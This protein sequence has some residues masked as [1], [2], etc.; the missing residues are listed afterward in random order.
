AHEPTEKDEAQDVSGELALAGYCP[1][2][3]VEDRKLVKG[4]ADHALEHEGRTYR[5]ATSAA[6]ERFE[7]QPLRYR[8]WRNGECP[9][10]QTEEKRSMPGE[11][12]W[13][14]LYAGRLFVFASD[15]NRK[16]FVANPE[17]YAKSE[18]VD[19]DG[20]SPAEPNAEGEDR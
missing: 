18:R 15:S 12:R 10:V 4:H 9:V 5:F 20:V 8:P 11:A 1:V 19:R 16:R 7:Q 2:S 6:R 13:G 3:L 17:L 14:A